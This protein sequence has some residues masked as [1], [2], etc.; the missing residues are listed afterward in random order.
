[1]LRITMG[2]VATWLL[3]PSTGLAVVSGLFS[4]AANDLYKNAGWAWVKL[5]TGVLVLEGTLVY[6]QAPMQ[7]AAIAAQA[8]LDGE[9]D[10]STLGTSLAAE[11]GSFWVILGVAAVNIGLAVFRPRIIR[12]IPAEAEEA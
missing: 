10:L 2:N 6:V 9:L 1:M 4:M 11:W 3:L 8:A 7:R 12:R 5:A